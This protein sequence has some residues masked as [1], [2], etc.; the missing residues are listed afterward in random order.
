MNK[1]VRVLGVLIVLLTVTA[2]LNAQ[3]PVKISGKSTQ[4]YATKAVL[5]KVVA[6][7]ISEIATSV[8]QKDGNF[9]FLFTPDYEGFYVVGTG[10]ADMTDQDPRSKLD[11]YFKGGEEIDVLLTDSLYYQQGKN[12]SKENKIMYKWYQDTYQLMRKAIEFGKVNSTYVDFFP[13]LNR[14]NS[15]LPAFISNNKSGNKTFDGY[16]GSYSRWTIAN[17]AVNLI[18]TPR[19]A[20]PTVEEWD[21]YYQGLTTNSFAQNAAE[22]YR[23]PWGARTLNTIQNLERRKDKSVNFLDLNY[24]MKV[25]PNDTL[26]GDAVVQFI[27]RPQNQTYKIY[28]TIMANFGKYV[29]TGVQKQRISVVN[30]KLAQLKAGDQGLNFEFEDVKGNK[31]K[32]ADLKGKVVLIDVWATWCAPCIAEIPFLKKLEEEFK[33]ADLAIVS[34]SSDVPGD[35]AKWKKMVEDKQLGG[36]QLYCGGP[37]EFMSYYKIESIPRFIL[38][39]KEGKIVLL[40][41]PRPSDPNLKNV[42]RQELTK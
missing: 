29:V 28:Q 16:F 22:L 5:Y 17:Y 40:H 41:S 15:K 12:T 14:V 35:K 3:S 38:F 36:I 31:V 23:Y 32:F 19:S 1:I 13:E 2:N 18:S 30:A 20:H 6:G 25:T 11:F 37:G 7:K 34:V 24:V 10:R 39:D 9:G 42:I 21:P 4:K 27:E 33:G 8:F 26:K